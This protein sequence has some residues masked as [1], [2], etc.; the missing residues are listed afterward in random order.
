MDTDY[1]V[2]INKGNI[3]VFTQLEYAR[4][5]LNSGDAAMR[6][7]N[8]TTVYTLSSVNESKNNLKVD[9]GLNL[10]TQSQWRAALVLS[11]KEDLDASYNNSINLTA[12]R[13][14]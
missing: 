1:I 7:N 2:D 8:E 12:T 10:I 11:R 14:F 3:R 9:V 6:Y 13:K 5:L 4:D